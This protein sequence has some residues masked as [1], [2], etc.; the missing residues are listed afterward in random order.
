[1]REENRLR[2]FENRKLSMIYGP[3]RDEVIGV[4]IKR[5]NEWLHFPYSLP[6]SFGSRIQVKL[7][8]SGM[9]QATFKTQ[10]YKDENY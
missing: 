7:D 8:G 10:A 1:M 5:H 9:Y 4:W 2:V 3:Y 6:K